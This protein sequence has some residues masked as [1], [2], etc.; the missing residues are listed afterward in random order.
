MAKSHLLLLC[1]TFLAC[2]AWAQSSPS[3]P[4]IPQ[5]IHF[6]KVDLGWTS[7]TSYFP[8]RTWDE[9]SD[10]S[11]S[12]MYTAPR[13]REALDLR[14]PEYKNKKVDFQFKTGRQEPLFRRQ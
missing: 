2:S 8:K 5:K 10:E 7:N 3:D 1:C 9:G 13:K 6:K 14:L 4:A 11:R 12:M